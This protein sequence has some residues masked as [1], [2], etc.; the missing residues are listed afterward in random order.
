VFLNSLSLLR[1]FQGQSLTTLLSLAGAGRLSVQRLGLEPWFGL[2]QKEAANAAVGQFREAVKLRPD[3]AE[4]H[5]NLG[6]ALMGE[7]KLK[8]AQSEFRLA[9]QLEPR[10][11]VAHY[12]LGLAL[13]KQGEAH[14]AEVEFRLAHELNPELSSVF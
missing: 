6:L 2:L 5:N 8:E 14:A 10:Y 11:A 7:G 3:L 1:A 13:K 12:N 9:L 4:A